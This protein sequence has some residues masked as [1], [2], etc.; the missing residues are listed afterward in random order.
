MNTTEHKRTI[1][2]AM[3]ALRDESYTISLRM[4]RLAAKRADLNKQ[5]KGLRSQLSRLESTSL[6]TD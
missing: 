2:F 3:Q 5:I 6:A 1:T 4:K